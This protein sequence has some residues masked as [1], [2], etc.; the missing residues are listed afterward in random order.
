M[1]NNTGT[2][3]VAIVLTV[4]QREN[5]LRCLQ[6]LRTVSWPGF[7]I[8][9][10]DNGSTDGTGDA[11]RLQFPEVHYHWHADNLGAAGGRN[12]G[13]EFAKSELDQAASE[14][15]FMDNDTV[16]TPDFLANLARPM[17]DDARVGQTAAKVMFLRRPEVINMAGGSD[18]RFWR[19]ST[20]A[21]GYDEL[22]RGQHDNSVDC[23]APT[24]CTLVRA[25][26]FDDVKGFDTAFD[27]YGLEDLD[28]SARIV[29][30]GYRC[31]Y[32]PEAVIY[33]DPTQTFGGGRYTAEYAKKKAENWRRFLS[34]HGAWHQKILFYTVGAP[35]AAAATIFRELRRGNFSAI[36]G[37]LRGAIA[38]IAP[39]KNN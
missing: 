37:L 38:R 15:L 2:H 14:Y 4:D 21:C 35:Y 8:V 31:V 32:A 6:S 27:P 1:L 22:D 16:V 24:C 39:G 13:V 7:E 36:A 34:R 33:H 12:A 20:R 25:Q 10:W 18:I 3:V 19:G 11:V 28:L 5:T 26:A 9:V 23:I 17:L 29:E 30:A